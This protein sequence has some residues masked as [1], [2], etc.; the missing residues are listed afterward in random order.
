MFIA[1]VFTLGGFALFGKN[2]YKVA[3]IILGV[4]IYSRI[5]CEKFSKYLLTAYLGTGL[6]PLISQ[7]SFGMKLNPIIAILLGNLSGLLIGFILV[8]LTGSFSR[9]HQRFSLYNVGF[10][11]G[12]I[13]MIFMSFFRLLHYNHEMVNK[14]VEKTNIKL[15]VFLTICISSMLIVGLIY[16]KGDLK[17]YLRILGYDG[18]SVIDFLAAEGFAAVLLNMG[19]MGILS[20]ALVLLTKAPLNGLVIGGIFTV[21]GFSAYEKHPRNTVPVI[22]GVVLAG[23]VTGNSISWKG[24]MVTALFSTALAPIVGNYGYIAGVFAGFL[25]MAL[26]SNLGYLHGGMNLYNNGFAVGFI[27]DFLSPLCQAFKKK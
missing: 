5:K 20:T 15:A 16:G 12:V 11:A 3:G 22:I 10:T 24:V 6:G 21:V 14:I 23:L 17:R 8:T 27:A 4:F 1:A 19:I 2:P 13:G 26:V 9:F 25:H 18:K 7:I